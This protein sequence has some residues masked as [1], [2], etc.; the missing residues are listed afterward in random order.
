MKKNL[1][2]VIN[3]KFKEKSLAEIVKIQMK[4]VHQQQV[5]DIV[6]STVENVNEEQVSK[7]R[8]EK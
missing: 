5:V 6:K 4:T 1:K 7:I 2:P 8:E 3:H